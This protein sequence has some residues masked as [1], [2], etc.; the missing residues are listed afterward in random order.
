LRTADARA[1]RAARAAEARRDFARARA[2]EDA[3]A[4]GFAM[5]VAAGRCGLGVRQAERLLGIAH[6]P[7][8]LREAVLD[9]RSRLSTSHAIALIQAMAV[10]GESFDL[11]YWIA[12]IRIHGL[13]VA[14]LRSEL[15]RAVNPESA[16]EPAVRVRQGT[17]SVDLRRVRRLPDALRL[18]AVQRIRDLADACL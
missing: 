17:L 11:G 15:K 16:T 4:K 9:P 5:K 10:A 13:S 18:A 2:I 3:R 12:S 8:A 1:A 7:A 6:G 14:A